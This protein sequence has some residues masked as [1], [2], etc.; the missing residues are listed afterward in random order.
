MCVNR[1]VARPIH[2]CLY[3]AIDFSALTPTDRPSIM[4]M[5]SLYFRSFAG[6]IVLAS[7]M[8]SCYSEAQR[9]PL[10]HVALT[11]RSSSTNSYSRAGFAGKTKQ[12]KYDTTTQLYPPRLLLVLHTAG[13]VQVP[14]TR[15]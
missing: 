2:T 10:R 14:W 5:N 13:R 3:I 1:A 9:L 12:K 7:L 8:V 11:V 15:L 4:G 6:M